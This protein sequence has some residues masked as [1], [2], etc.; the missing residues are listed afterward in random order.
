MKDGRQTSDSWETKSH[1][2]DAGPKRSGVLDSLTP[3]FFIGGMPNK[4]KQ[5]KKNKRKLLKQ[6]VKS[7]KALAAKR[8]HNS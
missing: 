2:R 5:Q 1:L 7:R 4:N 6:N 8:I 3:I